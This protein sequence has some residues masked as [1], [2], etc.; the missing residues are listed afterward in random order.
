MADDCERFALAIHRAN[1]HLRLWLNAQGIGATVNYRSVPTLT[2]YREKYGYTADDF[3]VSYEWGE[4]TITLPLF[5]SMMAVEQARVIDV[6]HDVVA[7]AV[8]P[9]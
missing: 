9:V 2:Y 7:P 4:G 3:P 8:F 5:P 1:K 6:V